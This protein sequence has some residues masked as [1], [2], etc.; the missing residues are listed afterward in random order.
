MTSTQTIEELSAQCAAKYGITREMIDHAE[1]WT[2]TD[3]DLEGLSEERVRGILDMRF[4]AIA[5]DTPRSELWH[6]PDTIDVIE[7]I[8]YLPDGGYDTEAGQ[9]RG[10]LLDLYLPHDAVLRCGHTL[11]VYIDIHGGGFTYGY[12]ELNRNFNVHL[13]ETGFAV[14]SLNYRPAP[15]TDLRGQLADVQAAL[16]WIKAHLTDYP[17]NPNAVFLT[18]D[19]AGGALTMLTLAI[20]NN[21]EAAAAFGVDEPS[22]IGF[23]GAAPVCGAYSSASLETMGSE[24]T[25]GYDPNRRTGLE[26]MLGVEFFDGIETADPKF[27]TAEGLAFNVNLPPLFIVTCGDDFLE[28]DNLALAA[29]LAR[30]GADF[31]LFDPKPRRHETLGH[32][33][34]IGMP[35]LDESVECF[36]RLR[37]FSYERC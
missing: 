16:R 28:A 25:V 30:K 8:P 2:E 10:H 17:V 26:Q 29:A 3:G 18:G 1:R 9:C 13:A 31:E 37:R 15:Q 14:F 4:G 11:P 33:F 12:K 36:E 27:L 20:E 34:V 21:A 6:T 35:W 22:G 7:D 5:V 32:V 19:S 24:L 23:A